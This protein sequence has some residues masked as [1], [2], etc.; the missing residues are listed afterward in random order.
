V[1]GSEF[2]KRLFW[3]VGV[4]YLVE[5]KTPSLEDFQN[6]VVDMSSARSVTLSACETGIT[7]ITTGN[8]DEFVCLLQALLLAGVTCVVSSLLSVPDLSTAILV[9]CSI[10]II[11]FWEWIFPKLCRMLSF[12]LEILLPSM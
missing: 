7:D 8:A 11:S 12:E 9:Y 10:S 3:L 1:P 5:E 4:H 2:S 6:D